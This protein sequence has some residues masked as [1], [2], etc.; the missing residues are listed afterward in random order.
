M[1][2]FGQ[3]NIGDDEIQ[4][5]VETLRSGWIGTG[6]RVKEFQEQFAEYVGS[7]FAIATSSCT[8]ALHLCMTA[9]GIG[10]GD[11]VITSPMTFC[12]TANAILHTGARPVFVDCHRRTMNILPN[13]EFISNR[14]SSRPFR[15][16]LSNTEMD[17]VIHALRDVTEIRGRQCSAA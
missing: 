10:P 17:L 4:S 7:R 9:S 5:V 11:E 13:A 6:P 12:A 15:S 14:T 16:F 3:P 2:V 1:L 8:A